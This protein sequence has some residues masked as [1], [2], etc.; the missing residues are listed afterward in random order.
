M[1]DKIVKLYYCLIY[2][3]LQLGIIQ[4]I[5]HIE[6]TCKTTL[7][8]QGHWTIEYYSYL[9]FLERKIYKS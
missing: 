3:T 7:P 1:K 2:A 5:A 8:G 4:A 6:Y 9:D